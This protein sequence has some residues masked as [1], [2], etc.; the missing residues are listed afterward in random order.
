METNPG[1]INK[2]CY[3]KGWIAKIEVSDLAERSNLMSPEE[4]RQYLTSLEE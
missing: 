1:L 2:G 3:E 4:Y